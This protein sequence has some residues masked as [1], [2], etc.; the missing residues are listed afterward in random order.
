MHHSADH[1]QQTLM[2]VRKS[3]TR[4]LGTS[5]RQSQAMNIGRKAICDTT[6]GVALEVPL[7]SFVGQ[8]CEECSTSPAYQSQHCPKRRANC[9]PGA[10]LR[11]SGSRC[12]VF[13][14][15][16][17]E[18][19]TE[20]SYHTSIQNMETH[21][22][23]LLPDLE[24]TSFSTLQLHSPSRFLYSLLSLSQL[25]YSSL[26]ILIT[27]PHIVCKIS[28]RSHT[29]TSTTPALLDHILIPALPYFC[30]CFRHRLYYSLELVDYSN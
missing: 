11:L 24:H 8:T 18:I 28:A 3:H 16:L 9:G 13:V 17:R 10:S 30:R 12:I 23:A 25:V 14:S 29:T 4:P 1:K 15:L 26:F 5:H 20:R 7:Q 27:L 2:P 6:A 21:H 22:N 19:G